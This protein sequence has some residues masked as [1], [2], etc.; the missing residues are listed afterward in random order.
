MFTH[1]GLLASLSVSLH[2]RH[3]VV[4]P[5][6]TA[7][8]EANERIHKPVLSPT[9]ELQIP[10]RP[11]RSSPPSLPPAFALRT[12][13]PASKHYIAILIFVLYST[14]LQRTGALQGS[15]RAAK[16]RE[17]FLVCIVFWRWMLPDTCQ[18]LRLLGI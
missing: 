1:L 15:R 2:K 12:L 18:R 8:P 10:L 17:P 9:T 3:L 4:C 7:P 13:I 11:N 14:T 6:P 5:G 16:S